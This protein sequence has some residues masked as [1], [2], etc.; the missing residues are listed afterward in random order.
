MT[1]HVLDFHV[2]RPVLIAFQVFV[3][4]LRSINILVSLLL[5]TERSF[6]RLRECFKVLHVVAEGC[7]LYSSTKSLG[8]G[9]SANHDSHL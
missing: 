8:Q 7:V 6:E 3:L 5:T 1:S 2:L 9:S 4:M